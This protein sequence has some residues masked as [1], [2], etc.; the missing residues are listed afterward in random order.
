MATTY[1]LGW[2]VSQ[3]RDVATVSAALVA[4]NPQFL[5][6]NASVNNDVLMAAL[7]AL[8]VALCV[9]VAQ[10]PTLGR[11]IWLGTAVGLGLLTKFALFAFWPL[12]LLAVWWK[13]GEEKYRKG[14]GGIFAS[15]RLL[16][17]S[18]TLVLLL[19]LLI[20]AWLYWRNW[21]LYG[22]P[23]VWAVHLAAKGEQVLRTTPLG[24]RDLGEFF[25]VHFRS[26]WGLFGWLNVQLAAW[27][28]AVYGLLMAAGAWG[29]LKNGRLFA[30]RWLI[31]PL[32]AS[33]AIY[34]SL[35]R[36]AL[37][38]NWSGYQGGSPLRPLPRW[39][40]CWRWA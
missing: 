20:A 36:Y 32:L 38:I 30:N 3:R 19:P 14:A 24:W 37:T 9:W 1:W 21:Q 23:L 39:R 2:L 35:G 25:S 13:F 12:A 28:Y 33:A 7:G 40:C 8:I 5:F 34:A 17:R 22:D 15:A 26:F 10:R 4:F 31:F 11:V 16:R 27:H 29:W 6:I 18:S